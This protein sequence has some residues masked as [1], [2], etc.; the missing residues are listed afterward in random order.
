[1]DAGL[2]TGGDYGRANIVVEGMLS[3]SKCEIVWMWVIGS[4]KLE[5][6]GTA[7]GCVCFHHCSATRRPSWKAR[8][9]GSGVTTHIEV[10]PEHKIKITRWEE[11]SKYCNRAVDESREK[12]GKEGSGEWGEDAWR[13]SRDMLWPIE[14]VAIIPH[15]S[16]LH[17]PY[18]AW[19]IRIK[20]S[21][22]LKTMRYFV[23]VF[24]QRL[25]YFKYLRKTCWVLPIMEYLICFTSSIFPCFNSDPLH[26]NVSSVY[27]R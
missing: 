8:I 11:Y 18:Q 21:C 4:G 26:S 12:N 27:Y 5:N 15:L 13:S 7:R 22:L 10:I 1:M 9:W 2:G 19:Q 3:A 6:Y 14:S 23:W 24:T 17:P 25:K 16:Q 20:S